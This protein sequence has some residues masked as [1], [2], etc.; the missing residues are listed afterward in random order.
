MKQNNLASTADIA[1][2][3][4]SCRFPGAPNVHT[5]WH[6][7]INGVE[8]IQRFT[9]EELIASGVDSELIDHPNYVAAKGIINQIESFDAALFK[10]NAQ[11]VSAMDPQQRLFLEC[12]WE[13]LETSGYVP[14]KYSGSIGVYASMA[15]S[16]YLQN[17]LL[18]NKKFL[19]SHDWLQARI[20]TSLATLSTQ[21][22][23]RLNLNGPSINLATA[24]S[25]SLVTIAT[26]CSNLMNH[27]CD[28]AIAGAAA[29]SVPQ[30]KGYLYQA[31][32]IESPD[33]HC[34]AFDAAARGT[35]FSNG[36]G[37]VIL[38]RLDDALQDRDCIFAVI[39]GYGINNDGARKV[40][41][42]APSVHGQAECI[43]QALAFAQ[44]YADSI[45]Y[46]E[47]HGTGTLLGDPIEITALT[48]AF[49]QHTQAKQFC[50][51][52][53][54]KTNIGHT[55]IASG[56]AS[57]IKTVLILKNR[58]IPPTLHYRQPNPNIDWEQTPFFVNTTLKSW[59]TE[60]PR[61]AGVNAS[62]IGGT[63]AFIL[64]EESKITMQSQPNPYEVLLF[65]A[66]TKNSLIQLRQQLLDHLENNQTLNLADLSFT[67]QVGR[68]AFDYRHALV[69]NDLTDAR[70]QLKTIPLTTK[71]ISKQK[72]V[73]VF[74]GQGAQYQGLARALYQSE[75]HFACWVDRCCDNLSS[76]V[77]QA[78]H[79]FIFAADLSETQANATQ[80]VQP[81]L[82]IV[83]YAL[84]KFLM[85]L[86]I[87]PDAMIG[88]SVGEYVA[89]CLAGVMDL[90]DALSLICNR[91]Q[92]MASSEPG[93]M[94][95]V[96]STVEALQP[97][98][99]ASLSLAAINTETFC[100]VSGATDSITHLAQTL[101][102]Q[103]I[104]TR[105]LRTSHAFH[106]LL[107]EPIL[108][109]FRALVS[110]IRLTIPNIPF[111]SNVTG[112]WI[113][114]EVT[115]PNYWVQHLRNT[116]QFYVGL[117]TLLATQHQF[118][119]E[120]GPN[121]LSS[122]IK[123]LS[124]ERN[125]IV[126]IATLPAE[127]AQDQAQKYFLFALA[128]SWVQGLEIN[129]LQYHQPNQRS[130]IP[131]PTYPF[132]RNRY[133]IMPDHSD[134]QQDMKKKP[135]E[136]WFYEP[137]W[138]RSSLPTASNSNIQEL[139]LAKPGC[140]L[141]FCDELGVGENIYQLLRT[142]QQTVI[143]I[144]SGERFQ[145][146]DEHHYK[147]NPVVKDDYQR[148]VKMLPR[149]LIC[150]ALNLWPLTAE[151]DPNDFNLTKFHKTIHHCFYTVLFLT[152]AL[153]EVCC[154]PIKILVVGNE[155]FSVL[156]TESI[157]PT[158]STMVGPCRVI[159][160]EHPNICVQT[161]DLVLAD[162]KT[163]TQYHL[164]VQ[165]LM[166]QIVQQENDQEN[167]HAY[168]DAY[169]W[170]QT[171]APLK[172]NTNQTVSF[173]DRGV[174][175]FTGGLGGIA[176]TL[177]K[178]IA[179]HCDN[180]YLILLTRSSFP[181]EQDWDAVHEERISKKISLLREIQQLGAKIMIIQTDISDFLA[182]QKT[183]LHIK[184]S[185]GKITGVVHAAGIAGGGLVQLKTSETADKVLAPKVTGTAVLMHLLREESLDFFLL[186]SSVSAI[187]GEPSQV[188]YC[189]ANAC[190]DAYAA[191]NF[192]KNT[193][194]TVVINWNTWRDI[195]MAVDTD[196]PSDVT[197]LDRNN[198]IS[199]AQGAQIFLD[200]LNN[201][202]RQVIISTYEINRFIQDMQTR[203]DDDNQFENNTQREAIITSKIYAPPTNNLEAKLAGIWQSILGIDKVGI[204]DDFFELGGH[205]LMALRLLNQIEKQ[206]QLK[207][208]LNKLQQ[209]RTIQNL[210]C[211]I[212]TVHQIVHP[213]LVTLRA[214]GSQRPLFC[215]HPISGTTF[216]Y[217]PLVAHLNPGYPIYGLQDPS[218]NREEFKFKDLTEIASYY[219]KLIKMIQPTGPYRLCGLSFGATLSVEIANQLYVQGEAVAPLI[220]LDGWAKFSD[221]QFSEEQFK[222][223]LLQRLNQSENLEDFVEIAWRRM[224][225]LLAYRIAP[226]QTELILMKAQ[227]LLP[228]Y[229]IID[230]LNNYWDRYTRQ[231]LTVIMI[232][233]THDS[234]LDE[235]NVK[236][237]AEQLNLSPQ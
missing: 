196:R 144:T 212:N 65:S 66:K 80:T 121:S 235:P 63:N 208:T 42:S 45:Q 15:D 82:F 192:L 209:A 21:L 109:S 79:T 184:N 102:Q 86:G 171:F 68:T 112:T 183:L 195:G 32:G 118:F 105:R 223:T 176:L 95:A 120:I 207:V 48:Q 219:L 88:H 177:A 20:A 197:F 146:I 193:Q 115:D 188:D 145:K 125:P 128:Q 178:K 122:F 52:G 203:Q 231:K 19:Q 27:A 91:A 113:T 61:R 210:V 167:I 3:G 4:M 218:M 51:I 50:A 106:S 151:H 47:A 155:L 92:L 233:G 137:T 17:N 234:I 62:G 205:S 134:L 31:E 182:T 214:E 226:I 64:L 77:R 70:Q 124:V 43:A 36:V 229:R 190:L 14:E 222:K 1:V 30:I 187:M 164:T 199:P 74:P 189:A 75:P 58:F 174:Y 9:R 96:V 224:Q 18:K 201:A 2:I 69:C 200:V 100:V 53:S 179:Q 73:F 35:V 213:A 22:S 81:V 90:T 140:W 108:E 57:F 181:A 7:L 211:T 76:S 55:D 130:R 132:D 11:D 6:N 28:L 16:L 71:K 160:Q 237:L 165:R 162:L 98:L 126:S 104:V 123:E 216:C 40:G 93:A 83:E 89:A 99:N 12:A 114:E 10:M 142:F 5:F 198:D 158:K 49:R 185:L 85:T 60:S 72:T 54:V 135:Y 154:Q 44:M 169:Q 202:N 59:E 157:D 168:R 153:I 152:Q 172:L 186:C 117:Q 227:E 220:L 204:T 131:L 23:Y 139:C 110:K 206:C 173:K 156:G 129:W 26:A 225:L 97:F 119:I 107:M 217:E 87:I 67:L 221:E 13:A 163:D 148:I 78:V 56:M 166:L 29:I 127:T 111:I 41:F 147:I 84:A 136:Q 191:V 194:R 39:K 46:I 101:K 175:L 138:I 116:V 232:P 170:T 150:Y 133:W 159:P 8:S 180:P 34:R 141:V 94:L 143:K 236:V 38:K 37:V 24:C 25:S 149:N 228:E 33:G 230:Q 215:L 103:G 161:V